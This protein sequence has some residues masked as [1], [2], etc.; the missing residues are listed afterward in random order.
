MGQNNQKFGVDN[1]ATASGRRASDIS[2]VLQW[3]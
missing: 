2:K 3:I 1:L